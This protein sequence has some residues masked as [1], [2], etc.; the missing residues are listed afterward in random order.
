MEDITLKEAWSGPAALGLFPHALG[1]RR[2]GSPVREVAPRCHF[3]ADLT[4]GLGYGGVR[5]S[6]QVKEV[7]TSYSSQ[8]FCLALLAVTISF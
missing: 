3:K 2:P 5:L 1:R 6:G 8:L 7:R 4:L